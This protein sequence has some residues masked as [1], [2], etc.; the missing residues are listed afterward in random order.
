MNPVVR[1]SWTQ[2]GEKNKDCEIQ[3]W[4]YSLVILSNFKHVQILSSVK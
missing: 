4:F 1:N 2:K 3:F